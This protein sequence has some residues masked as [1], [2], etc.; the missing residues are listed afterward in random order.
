MTGRIVVVVIV[1]IIVF[2]AVVVVVVVVVVVS[3]TVYMLQG[4][5]TH[6]VCKI[7]LPLQIATQNS[8]KMLTHRCASNCCLVWVDTSM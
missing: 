3:R 5:L 6:G 7:A 4:M 1:V 8:S 2:V